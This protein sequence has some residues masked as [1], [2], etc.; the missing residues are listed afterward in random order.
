MP[1]D[2]ERLHHCHEKLKLTFVEKDAER[3]QLREYMNN[4]EEH[5]DFLMN[6]LFE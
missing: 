6:V 4:E 3:R 2:L 1:E 5:D